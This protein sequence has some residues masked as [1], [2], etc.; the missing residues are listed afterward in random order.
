MTLTALNTAATPTHSF[1]I[2]VYYEDTDAGGIVYYANYLKFAERARTEMLRDAGFHH[3]AMMAGD[4]IMMAVRRVS[5]EYLKPARLDDALDV[6]TSVKG[7]GA[8][9]I[10]LDQSIQRGGQELCRVAVTIACVGRD[11]RPARLPA[12]LRQALSTQIQS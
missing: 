4:G 8:A 5:A 1:P 3:T 7:L 2:R 6:T 11:G 9:T 10:E 12:T